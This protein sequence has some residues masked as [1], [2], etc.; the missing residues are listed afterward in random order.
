MSAFSTSETTFRPMRR[1][2]HGG[3]KHLA[4]LVKSSL[5]QTDD[6]PDSRN[7]D[8]SQQSTVSGLIPCIPKS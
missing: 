2:I 8:W 7:T 5:S 4:R 3:T 6:L 1:H